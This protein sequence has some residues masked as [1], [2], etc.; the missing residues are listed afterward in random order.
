M[1]A[2]SEACSGHFLAHFSTDQVEILCGVKQFR[3]KILVLLKVIYVIKSDCI[4][5][6]LMGLCIWTLR[7]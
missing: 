5:K 6:D 4:K 1:F 7:N 3:P 2:A